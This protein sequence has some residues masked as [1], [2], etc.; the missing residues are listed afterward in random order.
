MIEILI[1][2][3]DPWHTCNKYSNE[4]E[5]TNKAIYDDFKLKKPFGFHGSYRNISALQG[6]MCL[7]IVVVSK[8]A[9]LSRLLNVIELHQ[10]L[11]TVH[12]IIHST[13]HSRPLNNLDYCIC[14]AS[15]R[16]IS[17]PAWIWTQYPCVSS[18]NPTKWATGSATCF[19]NGQMQRLDII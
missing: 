2:T 3:V 19:V 14:T 10:G 7:Y 13:S 16:Q 6:S 1:M 12:S 17:D 9:W 8:Q 5:R 15:M 11:Y 18:H 4:E